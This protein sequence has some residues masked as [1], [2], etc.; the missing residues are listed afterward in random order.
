M[1]IHIVF[2]LL[3]IRVKIGRV[4]HAVRMPE[5]QSSSK[6]FDEVADLAD[7]EASRVR[8][9]HQGKMLP[10]DSTPLC[11]HNVSNNAKS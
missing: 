3:T 11:M 5:T 2:K 4:E 8:L 10:N 6:L 7:T 9:V 1:P